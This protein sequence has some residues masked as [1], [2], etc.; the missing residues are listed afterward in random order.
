M[1][2]EVSAEASPWRERFSYCN[3]GIR[4]AGAAG[5]TGDAA[6]RSRRLVH[7]ARS[8]NPPPCSRRI[9]CAPT[10]CRG[11]RHSAICRSP[12]STAPDVFHLPVRGERR[13]RPRT[14]PLRGL[15]TVLA[16][17]VRRARSCRRDV[18]RRT[19]PHAKRRGRRHRRRTRVLASLRRRA[20]SA[21][22][23]TLPCSQDSTPAA[24]FRSWHRRDTRTTATVVCELRS[25]GVLADLHR[26]LAEPLS[27]VATAGLM[28]RDCVP[29]FSPHRETRC[30]HAC[31]PVTGAKHEH[32]STETSSRQNWRRT[33][34]H[35]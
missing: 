22:P 20:P 2:G 19:R 21:P 30:L 35:A 6:C 4:R 5:R 13:R 7:A 12:A 9:S 1:L 26:R 32:R 3:G 27:L 18:V 17:P 31:P 29:E 25:D 15:R 10:N 33:P 14:R 8:P 34:K 28:P 11:M 23:D 16:R 24:S